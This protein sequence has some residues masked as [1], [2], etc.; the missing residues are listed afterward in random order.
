MKE[1]DAMKSITITPAKILG[2][3]EKI[4]SI[5]VGKDADIVVWDK[6]QLD[7]MANVLYTIIDG[8]VVYKK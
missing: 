2:L 1:E 3:D 5:K 6:H 4:G 8:K 7:V